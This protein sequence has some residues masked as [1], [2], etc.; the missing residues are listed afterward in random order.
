M[1]QPH[2]TPSDGPAWPPVP[3][4][5]PEASHWHDAR[6][7]A[8][9]WR[10]SFP[11][12]LGGLHVLSK[13]ELKD[14]RVDTGWDDDPEPDSDVDVMQAIGAK[15]HLALRL[16]PILAGAQLVQIEPDQASLMPDWSDIEQAFRYGLH[17]ALPSSPVFLDFEGARGAPTLWDVE[18]WPLPFHLRGAL[19]WDRDGALCGIPFGS[20]GGTHRFGGTDYQAWSRWIYWQQQNEQP[21][22]PGPGD[23]IALGENVISWVAHSDSICAHQAAI[24]AHL[25]ARVLRVLWAV[26]TFELELA[27]PAIPRPER[28]RA[29]RAGQAIG[30]SVPGLPRFREPAPEPHSNDAGWDAMVEPCPWPSCHGRL[31]E[32][33]TLWHEALSSYD[34]PGQFVLRLNLLIQAMR[35]ITFALQKEIAGR[36]ELLDWYQH[37]QQRLKADPKLKW[38]VSARNHVV[39][40]GDLATNSKARAWIVGDRFASNP[41]EFT[42]SPT[43]SAAE[44]ARSTQLPSLDK[45]VQREGVLVVERRW[46]VDE[47]PGQELLDVLAHNYA[48]LA[49]L[50]EDAHA[51]LGS[52]T[53]CC[54][55]SLDDPCGSFELLPSGRV[56]CM[57]VTDQFRSSR[58][59][60]SDGSPISV[61]VKELRTPSISDEELRE[62]YSDLEF[63]AAPRADLLDEGARLHDLARRFMAKDDYH[64]TIAFLQRDGRPLS[65]VVLEPRDQ[66]EL[67]LGMERLATEARQLGANEL[68]MSAEG[69]EASAV[70]PSDPRH[71]LRAEDREDRREVLLTHALR[72]GG[73]FRTWRSPVSRVKR[74]TKLGPTTEDKGVPPRF[75][76]IIEE[77]EHWPAED[78][79]VSAGAD[80][81]SK[82]P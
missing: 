43:A 66:R 40:E 28:R 67:F 12:A 33:H 18:T 8:G 37:W 58:R 76:P 54:E 70:S 20:V 5:L 79:K 80:G 2:G 41:I 48:Q 51:Q 44:I 21:P 77:W 78:A 17:A 39:K 45:V 13:P 27:A 63:E 81:A 65:Q 72:R 16:M 75:A 22:A 14:L 73:P 24:G 4:P 11:M 3:D 55:K 9:V 64:I 1:A 42:V 49:E 10:D 32:A 26:E 53:A 56:A 50:V 35:N 52:Y 60:L 59:N 30:L 7:I 38:A 71:G 34:D 6:A 82:N 31:I 68:I 61:T 57:A 62:R 25:M 23:N 47:F 29:T 69:W 46:V 74:A 19:L 15:S 36:T